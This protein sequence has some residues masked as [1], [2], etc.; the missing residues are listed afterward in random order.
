[1]SYESLAA[2]AARSAE[3][4]LE[5]VERVQQ[6]RNV[7]SLTLRPTDPTGFV[8][9]RAGQHLAFRLG[10]PQRSV[11]TYTI[12]SSPRDR[13]RYRISVKHEPQGQGGS[14]YFH[15]KAQVGTRLRAL[16]PRG[17]F[18]LAEDNRPVILLSGGIGITPALSMLHELAQ[19]APRPVYFI[20]ACS[21]ASE[22]NFQQEVAG[23]ARGRPWIRI[24]TA[25]A[26]GSADDLAHGNCQHL[27]ILDRDM[28]R[29]WL[30]LDDYRVYMCGPGG[31]MDAMRAALTGLGLADSDIRQESFGSPLPANSAQVRPTA[32]Q[33][34]VEVRF[35][36]TGLDS[37]WN[38]AA[39]LLEFAEAQGLSPDFSCR[40]GVCGSCQ[41]GLLNGEVEY[42]EEPLDPLPP[43]QILL[44]CSRPKGP[45]EL[46]L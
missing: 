35:G 15:S 13:G 20:H 27:G 1:M 30:P 25:Y 7:V 16:A 44:C 18:V 12:S 19:G 36:R 33:S 26:A 40:A 4:E 37:T 31:F 42:D 22:H 29:G 32:E 46:D 11:A 14:D 8:P 5:V 9:F 3:I 28:L 10:L 34:G 23:I 39:N 6:S 21:D 17:S 41:C 2:S 45:I 24:L 43:G 38:G